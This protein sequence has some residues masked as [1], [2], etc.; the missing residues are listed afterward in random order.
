MLRAVTL[1]GIVWLSSCSFPDFAVTQPVGVGGDGNDDRGGAPSDAH[2]CDDGQRNGVETGIDCGIAACSRACSDGQGCAADSDCESASCEAGICLAPSCNDQRTNG[3]ETDVDCGGDAGCDAC[4]SGELCG[5]QSDCDGG[6]CIRGRCQAVSCGDEI[7]NATETDVD[8]GGDC[9]P[10]GVGQACTSNSDCDGTACGKGRC[11]SA[12]CADGV[13]NQDETDVDCGGSCPDACADAAR[14]RLATD[15]VSR[16][17]PRQTL[18]CAAPACDDGV[19]NGAEP[20]L[21]CGASCSTKCA[22]LSACRLA[23]D[24][25]TSY[26]LGERCLPSQATGE[27]LSTA[28]WTATASKTFGSSDTKY[29][30]DGLQNTDW[31]SGETQTAGTWFLID[32][33]ADRVFFSIEIDCTNTRDDSA[34]ALD[35]AISSDGSFGPTPAKQNVPGEDQMVIKFDQPQVGRYIKLTLAAGTSHWWRMDE[36]RVKQ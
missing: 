10:C 14:C 8:C 4:T 32:M 16:V 28:S 22:L 9:S 5:K 3:Q 17:C 25:A 31:T 15:C 18:R 20:N 27:K 11:E 2:A 21:D 29:A 35:V 34:A 13:Q 12:S 26:C 7:R 23:G 36:I 24:C 30:I 33:K 19:Q 6:D 1:I